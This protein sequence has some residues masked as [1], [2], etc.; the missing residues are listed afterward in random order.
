MGKCGSK[1][2]KNGGELEVRDGVGIVR[3]VLLKVLMPERLAQGVVGL[4]F[5]SIRCLICVIPKKINEKKNL[6]E[7][8]DGVMFRLPLQST[9]GD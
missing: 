5:G 6:L 9:T 4:I 7:S 3:V 2:I 1:G 8:N